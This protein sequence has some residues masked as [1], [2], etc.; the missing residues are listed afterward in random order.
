MHTRRLLRTGIIAAVILAVA[1]LAVTT[2]SAAIREGHP[3]AEEHEEVTNNPLSTTGSCGVER[4]AVKTGTDA[5]RSKIT[6]NST[7]ATTIAELGALSAPANLPSN[8]RV[9]P[10]E[11]TV[12]QVHATLTEYKLEA[13]SDYH[14]VLTD[15]SSHTMI[16]EIPDPACVG[17]PSP[18][19]SSIQKARSEFDA[20]YTPTTSFK[21]ANVAVTITGV[22]FFDFLH[23]Q[24]G[25]A[26]NGIELHSVLDVGF[27]AGGGSGNTV[28]VTNPG[29][30]TNTAGTATSLQIQARDSATNQTLTYSATGLP[31]GLSINRSSGLISGTPTTTGTSTSAVTAT[32]TTGASGSATF[33]WTINPTGGCAGAGQR[34]GNPGFET[35]TSAPWSGTAVINN[36]STEPAHSGTWDA[37]LDGHGATRTDTLS[38]TVTVPSGCTAYT[39]TFWL[40]INTA[41]TTTSTKY[42]T[43]TAQILNTSGTV[44]STLATCSNLD[45]N[46]GYAQ[47]SYN[48]ASYAGQTI[49]IK[50]TGAEDYTD[51][52]SFVLD[53]TALT[54]S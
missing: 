11:D 6:L 2:V 21:T 51:Q 37:W 53:D 43:F 24:T 32:D 30:R 12:Y 31:A 9:A 29:N 26:P 47:H 14:L 10:T 19:T 18:L 36:S 42:D 13:D 49:T 22:G 1:G 16:A 44:L 40:H 23:G 25:V 8:N 39:L 35:G 15:G 4:W 34:L 7:T 48:L 3:D 41:E 45:H 20:K 38:Q 27:G 5:D 46:T 50:F 28:T 52:T 54:V 33:T 17:A